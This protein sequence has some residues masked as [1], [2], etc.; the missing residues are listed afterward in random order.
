[1]MLR[2]LMVVMKSRSRFVSDRSAASRTPVYSGTKSM[3]AASRMPNNSIKT[4]RPA[5]KLFNGSLAVSR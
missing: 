4:I 3:L 5:S 1:M 2:G